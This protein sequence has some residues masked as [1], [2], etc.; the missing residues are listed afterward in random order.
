MTDFCDEILKIVKFYAKFVTKIIFYYFCHIDFSDKTM[1]EKLKSLLKFF[2]N[3]IYVLMMTLFFIASVLLYEPKGL[4]SLFHAGEGHMRIINVYYFNLTMAFCIVLVLLLISRL[5]LFLIRKHVNVSHNAYFGLCISELVA[6]SAFIAFYLSLV[7]GSSDSYFVFLMKSLATIPPVMV[8]P[9]VF[10]Y[11]AYQL[12]DARNSENLDEGVRLKFYDNRHL[13][14]FI[15]YAS[16]V[17]FIESNENYINIHYLD[18]GAEKKYQLRNTMKSVE[19]LSE[20]AG[21]VRVHRGYIVNPSHVKSVRKDEGGLYF[22]DLGANISMEVPVSKRYY[23][24]IT[25]LL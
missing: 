25:A 21:F 14:K 10:H 13:L 9:Q 11:L 15:T 5:T 2:P 12:H 19:T 3:V 17:L 4:C 6:I 20:K 7:S 16:S 18:A 24:N 23:N 22:A 8:I 1:N